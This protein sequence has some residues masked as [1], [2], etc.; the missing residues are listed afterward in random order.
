M[1]T[2]PYLCGLAIAALAL[3]LTYTLGGYR[4]WTTFY[5]AAIASSYIVF[6]S[7]A[8]VVTRFGRD[9]N[10]KAWA[11]LGCGITLLFGYL[12]SIR[13]VVDIFYM[14]ESSYGM[15]LDQ[16]LFFFAPMI[17]SALCIYR[18]YCL[19]A[20]DALEKKEPNQPSQPTPPSR[21]G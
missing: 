6:S 19:W 1:K 15:R 9:K 16:E 7:V 10:R 20:E 17:V 18:S 8:F 2:L 3:L 13:F 5:S 14:P 4:S 11:F 21:R 12:P